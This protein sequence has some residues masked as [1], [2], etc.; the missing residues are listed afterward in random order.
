MNFQEKVGVV[1]GA[2]SGIGAAVAESYAR[3]GG[4]VVVA[5]YDEAAARNVT[6]RITAAGGRALALRIDVTEVTDIER[7]IKGAVDQFVRID[8]LHNNAYSFPYPPAGVW[9]IS[10]AAWDHAL[11]LGL[12]ACFRAIRAAVPVMRRQ[13]GGSIVNTASISGLFADAGSSPYNAAKGGLINFTRTVAWELGGDRIR[14]NCVCPGVIETAMTA[15][16]MNASAVREAAIAQI[17]LGRL[18]QPQDIANVVLFLASDLAAFVTG[19]AYVVD[20]GQTLTTSN[21]FGRSHVL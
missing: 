8:F 18:G 11:R 20:G 3:H 21:V 15:P 10:D 13:G 12:M 16:A 14:A 6:Q 19:A 4:A 2:G 5:D 9:S 7:M 17:P 1:T